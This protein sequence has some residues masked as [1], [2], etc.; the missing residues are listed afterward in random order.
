M[1]VGLR[2]AL[3]ALSRVPGCM[4]PARSPAAARP[5]CPCSC[6]SNSWPACLPPQVQKLAAPNKVEVDASHR[7]KNFAVLS[8]PRKRNEFDNEVRGQPVHLPQH[9]V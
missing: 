2:G 6:S 5:V 1:W 4:R 9:P 8:T 7:G 3:P